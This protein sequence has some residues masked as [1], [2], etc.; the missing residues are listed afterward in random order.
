M[1]T[2]NTIHHENWK[3]RQA[4]IRAFSLLLIGLPPDRSQTLVNSSLLELVALVSDSKQYVQLS[5]VRS[6]SMISE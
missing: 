1:F 3:F 2:E 6:L 5:A 4:S